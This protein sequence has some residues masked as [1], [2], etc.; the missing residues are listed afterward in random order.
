M[1]GPPKLYKGIQLHAARLLKEAQE[2]KAVNVEEAQQLEVING[3]VAN[4]TKLEAEIK[5]YLDRAPK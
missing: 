2:L 5:A 4:L 3:I 1:I